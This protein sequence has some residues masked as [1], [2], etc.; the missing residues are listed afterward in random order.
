M[1]RRRLSDAEHALCGTLPSPANVPALS[2]IVKSKP[3][4]PKFLSVEARKAWRQLLP[5]LMERGSLTALD[6]SH[7]AIH[8]ETFARWIQA[9]AQIT[10]EGLTQ[11]VTRL[12]SNGT[13]V[14][15]TRP[16][17]ALKILQDCE[18][19][20]RASLRELGITPA[21]RQKITPVKKTEAED[22]GGILEFIAKQKENKS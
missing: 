21:S 15:S 7:L 2:Q 1:A 3:K 17:I 16:H 20:L 13:A 10:A 6:A 4:M 5:Q 14:S 9:Q 22:G 18:K 12:D 11:T 8:C 19:S